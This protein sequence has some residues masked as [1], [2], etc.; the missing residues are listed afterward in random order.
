ML[1]IGC[2]LKGWMC[3][4]DERETPSS[5]E[6]WDMSV[7]GYCPLEA[8]A[9]DSVHCKGQKILVVFCRLSTEA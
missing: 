8:S 9:K 7:F 2:G 4:A 5:K 1:A 3:R 6:F